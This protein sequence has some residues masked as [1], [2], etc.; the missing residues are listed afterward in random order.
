VAKPIRY[1]IYVVSGVV[2]AALVASSVALLRLHYGALDV[3]SAWQ[4]RHTIPLGDIGSTSS[5]SVLPLSE[6]HTTNDRLIGEAGVS[7][8]I[9]TDEQTYLFDTGFNRQEREPSP[10][11][12]NMTALG[13]SLEDVD[14]LFITHLH[15]DHVGCFI[16]FRENSFSTGMFHECLD[17]KPI[18]VPVPMTYPGSQP[19]LTDMPTVLG[20]GV[21]SIGTIARQLLP[22]P[23]EEQ[24]LA[25]NLRD[26]G[27]VLFVGCGHQLLAKIITRAQELFDQPI[28]A[29]VGGLHYPYPEGRGKMFG[30]DV[31]Y[32]L[33]SGRSPFDPIRLEEIDADFELMKSIGLQLVAVGGHDTSD[34]ILDRL[35]TD[36]KDRARMLRVGEWLQIDK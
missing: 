15:P 2:L 20:P 22:G 6:W 25:V 5:L 18:Y 7:Y 35:M 28:V 11:Q 4:S 19:I 12:H 10:L 33:G 8:L 29:V 21:A 36:F 1:S 9:R 17:D 32:R 23:V 14:A 16:W 3:E 26:R 27:I 30:I 24:A 31:Q 34:F 13:V